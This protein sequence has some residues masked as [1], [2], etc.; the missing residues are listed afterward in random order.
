M[1]Q[2][3]EFRHIMLMQKCMEKA[4][5]KILTNASHAWLMADPARMVDSYWSHND[6]EMLSEYYKKCGRGGYKFVFIT[7]NPE[8][9]IQL[10][11]FMRK[12][13][14]CCRKVWIT[15][16]LFCL[17]QRGDTPSNM[18][19]GMHSHMLF[20]IKPGKRKSE[21][22]REVR[23]TFKYLVGN[24]LEINFKWSMTATN[25]ENYIN[26]IKKSDDKKEKCEMDL[27][28]REQNDLE[29]T[30]GNWYEEPSD[31]DSDEDFNF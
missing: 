27:I 8:S 19:N 13:K 11:M 15:K 10:S 20:E 5:M 6:I 26:G 4:K 16:H 24:L 22:T 28:W 3:P 21:I 9:H 7:V 2:T 31:I 17:E 30:Y 23:N 25:F 29:A 18:G 1:E 14:K 12:L